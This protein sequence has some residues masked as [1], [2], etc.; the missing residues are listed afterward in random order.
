MDCGRDN[1]LLPEAVHHSSQLRVVH[2]ARKRRNHGVGDGGHKHFVLSYGPGEGRPVAGDHHARVDVASEV[3][4]QHAEAH[5]VGMRR[6]HGLQV[7]H[8]LRLEM[9]ARD[10]LEEPSLAPSLLGLLC[11]G[12]RADEPPA[13]EGKCQPSRLAQVNSGRERD[14][15]PRDSK[16][17]DLL[18]SSPV[19]RREAAC[20]LGRELVGDVE[21][22]VQLK[23]GLVEEGSG[24]KG[25][26]LVEVPHVPGVRT[27][28][29]EDCVDVAVEGAALW[30]I[31]R[32]SGDPQLGRVRPVWYHFARDALRF[33]DLHLELGDVGGGQEIAVLVDEEAGETKAIISQHRAY[34]LTH[35]PLTFLEPPL[36]NRGARPHP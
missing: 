5:V 33:D 22:D 3:V 27:L 16:L 20:L 32:D 24:D 36:Q 14:Q 4:W 29:S 26:A 9:P 7:D 30:V 21:L 13:H 8:D 23:R 17:V 1:V 25:E 31:D 15:G 6:L 12:L 28:P 10:V 19:R 18:R 11:E 34:C 35:R 2:E